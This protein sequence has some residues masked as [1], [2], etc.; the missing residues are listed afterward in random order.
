MA[1]YNGKLDYHT[2]YIKGER[3]GHRFLW[4]RTRV[5][6]DVLVPHLNGGGDLKEVKIKVKEHSAKHP[7][8]KTRTWTQK[9]TK[10]CYDFH[11]KL[12]GALNNLGMGK[13]A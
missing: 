8:G 10:S 6:Y 1:M 3:T 7:R 12:V 13:I 11:V 4:S 9:E 5:Y 2:A